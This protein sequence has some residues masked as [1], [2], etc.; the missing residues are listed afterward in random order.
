[1]PLTRPFGN[2]AGIVDA[3]TVLQEGTRPFNP[4]HAWGFF[5]GSTDTY[6]CGGHPEQ[7]AVPFGET[8]STIFTDYLDN[9]IRTPWIPLATDQDGAPISALYSKVEFAYDVYT[10]NPGANLV[11]WRFERLIDRVADWFIG[12]G[13][14]IAR[15]ALSAIHTGVYSNYLAWVVAGFV[16]VSALVLLR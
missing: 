1:M 16:L 9:E 14:A 2:Y 11:F 15:P 4:T 10:D 5:N 8:P 3:D 7:L 12:T 6:A 13:R